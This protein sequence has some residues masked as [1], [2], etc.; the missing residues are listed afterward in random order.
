MGRI[1]DRAM[2]IAEEKFVASSGP[3]G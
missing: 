2:A 1:V 3:G